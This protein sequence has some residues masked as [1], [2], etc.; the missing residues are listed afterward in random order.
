MFLHLQPSKTFIRT[1]DTFPLCGSR[2]MNFIIVENRC[3]G[4]HKD[5]V[6]WIYHFE[7]IIN[8]ICEKY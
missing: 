8:E 3:I 6:Y 5:S 7:M 2:E 1:K 4:T